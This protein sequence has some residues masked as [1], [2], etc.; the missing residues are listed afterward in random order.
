MANEK[1]L[2]CCACNDDFNKWKLYH[3][4][5]EFHHRDGVVI[6]ILNRVK[7]KGI[8]EGRIE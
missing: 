6:P 8:I 2:V 5:E 3:H 1:R 7:N 4:C